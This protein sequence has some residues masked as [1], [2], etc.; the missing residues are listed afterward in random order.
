MK[1]K[2]WEATVDRA[3][4]VT[5]PAELRKLSG[6][7][8]GVLVTYRDAGNYIAVTPVRRRRRKKSR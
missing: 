8:P 7:H 5:I 3:G 1:E 2:N 4:R 6:L